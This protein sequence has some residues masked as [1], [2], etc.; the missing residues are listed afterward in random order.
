MLK[1]TAE[2]GQNQSFKSENLFGK[3]FMI[4]SGGYTQRWFTTSPNTK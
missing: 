4:E 3:D 1:R 2:F